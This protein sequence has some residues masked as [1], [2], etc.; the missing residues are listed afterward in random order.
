MDLGAIT[1]TVVRR[2]LRDVRYARPLGRNPLLQLD[3]ITIELRHRGIPA[4]PRSR[5]WVLG[6]F[7]E[8]QVREALAEARAVAG[9]PAD[10]GAPEFASHSHLLARLTTDFSAG[11]E[12]LEAWSSVYH[13]YLA[14]RPLP[15]GE[16]SQA[17]GLSR[18][19][20]ARRL[21]TGVN[22]L[23]SAICRAEAAA[24][25]QVG[26]APGAPV[27]ERVVVDT[28]AGEL[29]VAPAMAALL[30]TVQ[31]SARIVR[32][33]PACLKA[34]GQRAVADLTEYRLGRIAEW[35][36]PRYALDERF[37]E[38][39][40]LVDQGEDTPSG[41]W[42]T[43]G[44]RY[45]DLRQ[46]LAEVHEPALVLLGP[47]G[48]GK[49]TLLRRLELDLAV[50]GLR[51]TTDAV[52]FFVPLNSY[53]SDP[54]GQ[55]PDAAGW[56]DA[57]WRRRYPA[58][59]PLEE[60]LAA[61]RVVLLLD[62]LNEMPGRG[63]ADYREQMLTWR[64]YLASLP[65][66]NRV[67]FSCRTLDYT[68][69]L[70]SPALRVP[71]VVIEPLSDEQVR[72]FLTLYAPA[73]AERL[74]AE[75]AGT[76]RLDLLRS[77]Y[78][79]RLL[80]EQM[81]ITGDSPLGR[82]ALF[83]CFVRRSLRREIRRDSRLFRPDDLIDQR[84]YE[85]LVAT[86]RW[87]DPYE[88]PRRGCLFPKLAQL[89]YDMQASGAGGEI[90]QIRLAYD[91]AIRLLAH[92]DAEDILRAGVALSI[93]DEDRCRDEVLY[94]HQL[95]QEYFAARVLSTRADEAASCVARPWRRSEIQ[96]DVATLL[97]TLPV[98]ELLPPLPPTGWEETVVLAA[99]M[100]PELE[101]FV[102]R[103][104]ES[105]LALAGRIAAL[106]EVQPRLASSLLDELR[107][108]LVARS[109]DPQADLRDRLR[110]GDVLGDLGDPR[111]ERRTGPYG[112]YLWPP[113][114][115]VPGGRYPLGEDEPFRWNNVRTGELEEDVDHLPRHSVEIQS[116][117]IARF[118][119]TTA[120]WLCF[121]RAGGY[122]DE[123]WW[124]TPGARAWLRGELA[125][126]AVKMNNR[127]W[128]QRFKSKPELFDRMVAEG[129][130]P[131]AAAIERWRYWLTLDDEQ[132]EQALDSHWPPQ[133]RVEPQFWRNGRYNRP[134]QPVVGVCW[135]EA[136]AYARWLAAQTEL[137]VRLPTEAEWEAAARGQEGRAF[138][139]GNEFDPLK[140][141]TFET[142][143]R[144]PTPIGI[145]PDGAT[146]EGIADLA[147]NAYEWT[148]SLW[149]ECSANGA[150]MDYPY[151][152]DAQDGREDPTAPPSV[153]R[154]ARGG[155]W[156]DVAIGARTASRVHSLPSAASHN[157][158]LRI[159]V[160]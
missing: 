5:E 54:L 132:F 28:E 39:T 62:G 75:L 128:R 42:R 150:R 13:R 139:W 88:L 3:V 133:R 92:E 37:V 144:Q 29:D 33:R 23:T 12:I 73:D 80:V 74:W 2:A 78:F 131:N 148:S 7:L 120:E 46:I 58:L 32:L 89:A 45:G 91:E 41:R 4:S 110:C 155:S 84:D 6:Q 63:P 83:T 145:F 26:L 18:R 107:W 72:R 35:C 90:G 31:D 127:A 141:N 105:N 121:I 142:R 96:P 152:Y 77:P 68:A 158:G 104:M 60:F 16:M 61:G 66:G 76:R 9:V 98:G 11:C 19:T 97:A 154:I 157:M 151:P 64:Q 147:G 113:L 134:L 71:H 93:L 149:G 47:P 51:G 146:P 124:D 102:R 70:S 55:P 10:V 40:L 156:D 43:S 159:A 57:Q 44:R 103:L 82:A 111:F 56:L 153:A 140:A 24:Q 17:L 14:L 129:G 135:Y 85:R 160:G 126:E 106:P 67:V 30:A 138:P 50:D 125:N 27:S 20:L 79:L 123:R 143:L 117:Q 69:P 87:R 99:A 95:L 130:F 15:L 22:L 109:G 137:K 53:R 108:A 112:D 21:D 122:D 116:F 34:I 115:A 114:V 25:D 101:C 81:E 119:V 36:Q 48:C 86:P 8:G 100:S 136:V 38:L 65:G 118:P 52:S 49:S 94:R 1:P 59:P